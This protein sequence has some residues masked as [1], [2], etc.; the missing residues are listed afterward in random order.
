MSG[1]RTR[2]GGPYQGSGERRARG[3]D[4][5]QCLR[6]A[7][8]LPLA[9]EEAR[10]DREGAPTGLFANLLSLFPRAEGLTSYSGSAEVSAE[11]RL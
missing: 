7:A 11:I 9:P 1:R 5:P 8:S 2:S 6:D 3:R 4:G 10:T